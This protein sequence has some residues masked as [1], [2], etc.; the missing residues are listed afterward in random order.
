[1]WV[2]IPLEVQKRKVIPEGDGTCLLSI[3]IGEKP[4]VDRYH[5]F[6]QP[7][8]RKGFRSGLISW[9]SLGSIPFIGTENYMVYVAQLVECWIV[10]P[11][12]VGS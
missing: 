3:V 1:M 2:R 11:E 12:V 8:D 5:C 6:P 4:I 7:A 10:I 9:M